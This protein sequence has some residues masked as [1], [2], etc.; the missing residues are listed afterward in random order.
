MG[1]A[2][3]NR[4]GSSMPEGCRRTGFSGKPSAGEKPFTPEPGCTYENRGGGFYLCLSLQEQPHCAVMENIRSG[5]RLVAH[6][7]VQYDSGLIEWGFST[8]GRFVR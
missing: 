2:Y 6:D 4:E 1:K 3:N 7:I 5:W 8:S